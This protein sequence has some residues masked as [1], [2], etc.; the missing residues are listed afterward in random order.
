L[1]SPKTQKLRSSKP[2]LK[3]NNSKQKLVLVVDRPINYFLFIV[4]SFTNGISEI[5]LEYF[6]AIDQRKKR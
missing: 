1:C 3:G 2:T 4:L 5:D 6:I